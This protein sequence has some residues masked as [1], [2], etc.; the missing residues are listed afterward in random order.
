MDK[1]KPMRTCIGCNETK[2][3]SELVRIV[4]DE[5][6]NISY[7][8]TGRRNGRGAYICSNLDCLG[9]AI[10]RKGLE[11]AFK[12]SISQDVVESLKKELS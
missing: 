9:K 7:D 8:F 5:A 6:G 11:R 1:K 2:E 3:K 10:K 12:M 4:R